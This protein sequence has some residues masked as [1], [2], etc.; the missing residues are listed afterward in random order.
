MKPERWEK[1]QSLFEKALELN[2]SER[3]NF[4]KKECSNDKELYDEIMSLLSADENQH[5]VFSGFAA[6]YITIDDGNLDGK[7]FGNYRIIKQIGVGG[8]GSVYLAERVDG[9]FEQKVALK[10]VKPGMNSFEI[11]SRFEEERQ[12]LARLQ[13]PNIATLLDG[14]ISEL[15]LPYFTM[16]YVEGKPITEYTG[17]FV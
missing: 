3:E 13:H 17:D 1:I 15:G 7:T 16:E 10:I 8:M 5:S 4:L 12:I 14:G 9:V 11:I 6:D 2:P